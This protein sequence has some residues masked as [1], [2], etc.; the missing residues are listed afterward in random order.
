MRC[1]MEYATFSLEV[2]QDEVEP[3]VRNDGVIRAESLGSDG[4]ERITYAQGCSRCWWELQVATRIALYFVTILR[5][6]TLVA[7]NVRN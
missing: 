4:M 1:F 2:L 6:G 5:L 3:G 7:L